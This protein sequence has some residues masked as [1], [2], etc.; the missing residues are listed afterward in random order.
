MNPNTCLVVDVWEGQLEIDEAVLKAN[1]VAGMIIRINNMSGGHHMDAN[2]TNQ[3]A[4][5]VNFV[6]VPYFVY[7]PWV[8]GP[9]NFAWLKGNMPVGCTS[10][11]VD[12]EVVYP[13]YSPANYAGEMNKLLDLCAKEGWKTII[14][15]GQGFLHLLSK[16][17]KCDYWWAQYP[18]PVTYFP[19]VKTW[20]DL[21]NSL[22]K[23]SE[24]FNKA[25]CPGTV[26]MWQFSG[27][28]L[29]L[30]G[31]IRKI[32]VSLFYGTPGEL[33]VYFGTVVQPIPVPISVTPIDTIPPMT[34]TPVAP[35]IVNTGTPAIVMKDVINV[36]NGPGTGYDIVGSVKVHEAVLV[37]ST[38]FDVL[39]NTWA[40]IGDAK[41][42]VMIYQ[43]AT[44][45]AENAPVSLKVGVISS[46]TVPATGTFVQTLH[47]YEAQYWN[48]LPRSKGLGTGQTLPETVIL[49]NPNGGFHKLSQEWQLWWFELMHLACDHSFDEHIMLSKW[50]SLTADA[51]AFTDNNAVQ[52][53]YA[54]YVQGINLNAKRPIALKSLS[55][56]GNLCKV[57]VANGQKLTIECLDVSKSPPPIL[58]VWLVK[59]WLYQ[60]ASQESPAKLANGTYRVSAFP[61]LSPYGSP[62]PVVSSDGS[63][64]QTILKSLTKPVLNGKTY[65]IY[66]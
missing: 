34:T 61:Q 5:A 1:G 30:P 4:Q 48:F 9:E 3:W 8:T 41:W 27:D 40:Q 32:D 63:G 64:T 12:T 46:F 2:F 59:P 28:Y 31:T 58:D 43:G 13:G 36:R 20:D 60:W 45:I 38:L 35:P 17:P 14:Y 24:P 21:K 10:V 15:T 39:N 51:R 19:T 22:D 26:K 55:T 11:A 49:D 7:N 37:Y 18:S 16:W 29:V 53:G 47:D 65:Q 6:R 50:A 57:L 42:A 33:A 56:G 52:N 23:L 44:Y 62:V 66:N 25:L 54:D